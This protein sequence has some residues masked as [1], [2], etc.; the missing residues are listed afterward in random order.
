MPDGLYKAYF[1]LLIPLIR[2]GILPALASCG[3]TGRQS[4][5]EIEAAL[6][7]SP[8]VR[9][10]G[11]LNAT[12]ICSGRSSVAVD[13]QAVEQRGDRIASSPFASLQKIAVRIR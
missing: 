10:E 4:V 5:P 11:G 8:H 12:M 7:S 2:R 9:S 1:F 6:F 13:M 3:M